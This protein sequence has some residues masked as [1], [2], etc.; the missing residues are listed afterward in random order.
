MKI[1]AEQSA[2]PMTVGPGVLRLSLF[3]PPELQPSSPQQMGVDEHQRTPPV[4]DT[5]AVVKAHCWVLGSGIQ[6]MFRHPNA[7]WSCPHQ[8][9]G[10]KWRPLRRTPA[11]CCAHP[12]GM[13]FK[14]NPLHTDFRGGI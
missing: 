14:A 9:L 3:L 13:P 8:P 6:G 5:I 10:G 2:F 12:G 1:R 11:L 7:I 4:T